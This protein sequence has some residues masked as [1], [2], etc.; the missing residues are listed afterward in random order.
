MVSRGFTVFLAL[1][2]I[3]AGAS[4]I[5]TGLGKLGW[6]TSPAAL[7]ASFQKFAAGAA[8]PL[9]AKYVAF[10]TPHAG[11][12]SKLVVMGELGL[13]TLL[14]VGFLTPL[15]AI[16]A[17]LMTLNFYFASSQVFTKAFYMPGPCV[18]LLSLLV[19]FA[20]RG[21]TVLGVDGILAGRK[22]RSQ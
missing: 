16:L 18:F 7:Q 9:V 6:F 22:Q 20:G 17:F 1:L 15:A 8:N 11:L 3:A 5:L 13:G 4:L 19:V 2:R 21:G 10:V 14:L 12:F